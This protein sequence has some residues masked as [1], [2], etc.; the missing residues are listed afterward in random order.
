VY[1][2]LQFSVEILCY[3]AF[4]CECSSVTGF[5]L[6]LEFL[7]CTDGPHLV[8]DCL[9]RV[10]L[11]GKLIVLSTVTRSKHM[12]RGQSV[13]LVSCSGETDGN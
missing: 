8:S 2:L 10:S 4:V 12:A 5:A 9:L 3:I 7:A 11:S 1:E 13:M 6:Y